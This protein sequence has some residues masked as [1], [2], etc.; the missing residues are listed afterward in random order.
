M[1]NS[2]RKHL[3]N[4]DIHNA[5]VLS[6]T[7]LFTWAGIQISILSSRFIASN[8]THRV[9]PDDL[10]FRILP[11]NIYFEYFTD[12]IVFTL[13]FIALAYIFQKAKKQLPFYISTAWVFYFIRAIINVFTPLERPLAPDML[14]GIVRLVSEE[15]YSKDVYSL[16]MFPSGHVGITV[17]MFLFA[18]EFVSKQHKQLLLLLV[19][20]QCFFMAASRGHYSIDIIGGIMLA[21]LVYQWMDKHLREG[22][23]LR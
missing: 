22:L 15:I 9:K 7:I 12:I 6:W 23:T 1:R 17:L 16:G 10:L 14:H 5:K 13:I 18:S 4:K 11:Y 8:F 19:V 3:N 21:I 20:F 2:L